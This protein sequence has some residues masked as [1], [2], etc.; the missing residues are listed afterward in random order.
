[1]TF[2]AASSIWTSLLISTAMMSTHAVAQHDP[3]SVHAAQAAMSR[4]AVVLDVRSFDAFAGG[5]L[6]GAVSVPIDAGISTTELAARVSQA[7]VDVSREVI[8]VGNVDATGIEAAQ[9][10]HSKLAGLSSGRVLWLVGGVSEWSLS[11]RALVVGADMASKRLPVPQ[12]LVA[13]DAAQQA[14]PVF[15]GSNR[16]ATPAGDAWVAVRPQ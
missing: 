7:G 4:S 15:A 12:H 14:S 3:V 2:H 16:R 6:P 5:H 11:G 1:M 8:V 9:R 13:F 10:I